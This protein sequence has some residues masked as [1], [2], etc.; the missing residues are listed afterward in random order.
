M[1]RNSGFTILEII[2]VLLL[3]AILAA[4]VIGRSALPDKLDLNSATEKLRLQLRF[5]QAQAMKRSDKVW[6]VKSSGTEYWV[7]RD[8]TPDNPSNE[9]RVPGGDY[10]TTANRIREADLGV[11][12]LRLHAI[13]RPDRETLFGLHQPDRQHPPCLKPLDHHIR[14]RRHAHHHR[15]SRNRAGAVMEAGIR[16][17]GFTLV[18]VIVTILVTAILSSI[19]INFMG[20]AMSRSVRSVEIVQGEA[21]AESVL[22]RITADY[23]LRT[24]QN[25]AT[26]LGLMEAAINTPPKSIYGPDV[27]ARYVYFDAG[28][29]ELL[30]TGASP[31]T[32]EV[33]VTAE[34]NDLIVLLAKTRNPN[35]PPV[36]F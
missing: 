1:R 11:F 27:S 34:G 25:S 22:E 26:A 12:D 23:V 30:Y 31:L 16:N 24:N 32:L 6:G 7:F 18:E 9:F 33:K 19:F 20:T 5:A 15:R 17:K 14:Q 28:G 8:T 36:L 10:P 35:S 29:N 4:T 21:D 3:M 2:V 13:L